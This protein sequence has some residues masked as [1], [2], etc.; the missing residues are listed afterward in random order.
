MRVLIAGGGTGGHL[1]PALAIAEELRR[2][3]P[4]AQ[5]L[6][7]GS[8]RGMEKKVVPREGFAFASVSIRGWSRKL[9][10]QTVAFPWFLLRGLMGSVLILRRFRPHVAVGTG[11]YV[12]GPVLLWASLLGVPTLIQEQNSLPGA[13]TRILSSRVDQVHLSFPQSV[14]YFRRRD[15]LTVSGNPLRGR[16]GQVGRAEALVALSLEPARKTVLITGGSQGAHS[17][18]MA[19]AEGLDRILAEDVQLIWQT[20]S[21]DLAEIRKRCAR[22]GPRVVVSDFIENMSL[23]YGAADMVV[24]RAGATTVAEVAACGLP[25]VFVPY[26]Y[27]TADHQRINAL[28]LVE[29]GAAEMVL[30]GELA[31]GRLLSVMVSLLGDESRMARMTQKSRQF[32]RPEAAAR[33]VRAIRHLAKER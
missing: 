23:A 6:F 9:G 16:V 10:W 31:E 2:Q 33:V 22:K 30:N 3:V 8:D 7:V 29:A 1:F 26:P 5:I 13:T 4:G 28:A 11:G 25:A 32:G 19:I 14:Q 21:R 17:I 20:G 15:H 24:C 27:A 18:N 12:S